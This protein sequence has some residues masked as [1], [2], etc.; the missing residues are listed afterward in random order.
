MAL[1]KT[2]VVGIH[3]Q[4]VPHFAGLGWEEL[5][6]F[7]PDD[8]NV[9]YLVALDRRQISVLLS[10]LDQVAWC[11]WLWNVSPGDAETGQGINDF[12]D[13]LKDCLMS[14]CNVGDLVTSLEN[15]TSV[16]EAC[17][18]K[19]AGRSTQDIDDPPHD[20]TVEV[21]PG[22]QF[23]DQ[24]EYHDAK[25]SVANAIFDTIRNIAVK[26]DEEDVLGL[27]DIGLGV[28]A[29]IFSLIILA[30]P[31]AWAIA[32]VS[33]AL[34]SMALAIIAHTLDFGDMTDALNDEHESLVL[35]LYNASNAATARANFLTILAGA[36]PEL[37]ITE[38]QFV[39]SMLTD[40]LLSQ[41]FTPRGDLVDYTS[42]DPI[43]CGSL[44]LQT[45]TFDT[46]GQGWIFE[47]ISTGTLEAT[48]EWISARE[49]WEITL[50]MRTGSGSACGG[51]IVL[52]GLAIAVDVGNSVQ[53]DFSAPSD[54][55]TASNQRIRVTY[56][57]ETE[58]YVTGNYTTAGTIIA[59][60]PSA[61]T[62]AEIE[63]AAARE[64]HPAYNYTID[65]EEVRVQ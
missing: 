41:L 15:L 37:V 29:S 7:W 49:A 1:R 5:L 16:I 8:D 65:L 31:A 32:G 12:T 2:R 25:C 59:N 39:S 30:G 20:G 53:L 43:D 24:E 11:W 38:R 4:Y 50:D 62:I 40:R 52:D 21:G 60:I 9:C 57:D 64:Y 51:A 27:V 44:G 26:L 23:G 47:D 48:G 14:G 36:E 3:D 33:G 19:M 42:P 46:S 54:A 22:Q 34:V 18:E 28:T 35:V 58:T 61:K 13:E 55:P 17:C 63:C 45:W 6:T 56:S 10:L